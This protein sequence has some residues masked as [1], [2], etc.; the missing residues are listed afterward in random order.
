[1]SVPTSIAVIAHGYPCLCVC[2][3]R[4]NERN[5]R[6]EYV[7]PDASDSTSSAVDILQSLDAFLIQSR[8]QRVTA[9]LREH[10]SNVR[11]FC[12]S[13]ELYSRHRRI[14]R[15]HDED[16]FNLSGI[17]ELRRYC[18]QVPAEAQFRFVAAFL[19]HRVPAVLRSVKQWA[20]AGLDNVTAEK[21][22]TLR[23]VLSDVEQV[24]EKVWIL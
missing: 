20:L 4:E 19:E 24:F 1:M 2:C 23:H 22:Q 9:D 10:G 18:Q 17:P 14:I 16:Y 11:I 7:I 13:N 15:V 6:Y 8:N 5:A 21:A 12:V 3:C